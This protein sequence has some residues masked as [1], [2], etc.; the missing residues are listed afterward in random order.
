[1]KLLSGH[2]LLQLVFVVIVC[3]VAYSP[4]YCSYTCYE[5]DSTD[6]TAC[7]GR[8][9]CIAQDVCQCY[10]NN[11]GAKCEIEIGQF[12]V[13]SGGNYMSALYNTPY[14][15]SFIS[16]IECSL[17]FSD[18]NVTALAGSE[19]TVDY[20]Y[21]SRDTRLFVFF[22]GDSTVMHNN[23]V[24]LKPYI[25]YPDAV[26]PIVNWQS[27][28]VSRTVEKSPNPKHP[29]VQLDVI[30]NQFNCA[31]VVLDASN[32]R[33]FDNR[34]LKYSFI[35]DHPNINV[36]R[37]INN[38]LFSLGT[39]SPV[40]TIP[41]IY[42]PVMTPDRRSQYKFTLVVT[43]FFGYQSSVVTTVTYIS[44]PSPKLTS[45][46]T[47]IT[48]RNKDYYEIHT[49]TT[50]SSECGDFNVNYRWSQRRGPDIP[51]FNN[52]PWNN[53]DYFVINP[54]LFPVHGTS[55]QLQLRVQLE[56]VTTQL[57][58]DVFIVGEPLQLVIQGGSREHP[59][60]EDL[61]L[62]GKYYDP[63]GSAGNEYVEWTCTSNNMICPSG[64]NEDS[65]TIPSHSMLSGL[66]LFNF[67][68]YKNFRFISEQV[69]I[70]VIAPTARGPVV[71][72]ENIPY[73]HRHSVSL[74]LI[75]KAV[76][77]NVAYGELD[78]QW[79]LTS[80]T[81]NSVIDPSELTGSTLT[82]SPEEKQRYGI[83]VTA[84]FKSPGRGDLPVTAETYID[85]IGGPNLCN[86]KVTPAVGYA[87]STQ[88]ELA[89]DT[90][91]NSNEWIQYSFAVID[92]VGLTNVTRE[93]QV[94]PSFK[95]SM[96]TQLSQPL[97]R[98][99]NQLFLRV[100]LF[101]VYGG[102]RDQFTSVTVN[103]PITQGNIDTYHEFLYSKVEA[104]QSQSIDPQIVQSGI[105]DIA[106]SL[107]SPYLG[108]ASRDDL[109]PNNC[110]S[111][112]GNG[113]CGDLGCECTTGY[114]GMDCAIDAKRKLVRMALREQL[115]QIQSRF[116][117]YA[118]LPNQQQ[119]YLGNM[120]LVTINPEEVS[121]KNLDLTLNY[122]KIVVNATTAP[123]D[124]SRFQ[125]IV[126][127]LDNL[128]AV[129]GSQVRTTSLIQYS[130]FSA[131]VQHILHDALTSFS[132]NGRFPGETVD[133]FS[134]TQ[135]RMSVFSHY[136]Y[137]IDKASVTLESTWDETQR[138][139]TI[140]I[141]S[142]SE[143][144]IGDDVT[145]TN[146]PVIGFFVYSL[147]LNPYLNNPSSKNITS[148]VLEIGIN[149]N[150]V[151][152]SVSDLEEA[153]SILF[154]GLFVYDMETLDQKTVPV[155]KYWNS[156]SNTW[157]TEGVTT[158]D[159]SSTSVECLTNHL[160]QFAVFIEPYDGPSVTPKPSKHPPVKVPID[161]IWIWIVLGIFAGGILMVVVGVF[162]AW[163]VLMMCNER[164]RHQRVM[165][166][167]KA[168]GRLRSESRVPIF[169][170][171]SQITIIDERQSDVELQVTAK[172]D[173]DAN[174]MIPSVYAS[175]EVDGI[176]T[177]PEYVQTSE[178][179]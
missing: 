103:A 122:M 18:S 53:K 121:I 48:L 63:T 130:Q 20:D 178:T 35:V 110:Y 111:S 62:S 28:Y 45:N 77:D 7:F 12:V 85:V 26:Y 102:F 160:S 126:T 174:H 138:Y 179:L 24:I 58:F 54:N 49:E 83:Q 165:K 147:G 56:Y 21:T 97:A 157:S 80:G 172:Q 78:L 92:E 94:Y 79:K 155:C 143:Y 31:P 64:L 150:G 68:Y 164:A 116:T 95:T 125:I 105:A 109:C 107:N 6:S 129:I 59:I 36:Q 113:I 118:N 73:L 93:L 16:L 1:M 87:L 141:P 13:S 33:S 104:L 46:D 2:V 37:N 144:L 9:R 151:P 47:S 136:A 142:I 117:A 10:G 135:L 50:V 119:R 29:A 133:E 120:Q 127:I 177:S 74:P 52:F 98:F 173:S 4:V 57:L 66:H 159:Y 163:K 84:S 153:L 89:C 101:D 70:N 154:K 81:L 22:S 112:T 11:A 41:A 106:V 90:S 149:L 170:S 75:L 100:R 76:I 5:K 158:G 166:R 168:N 3:F 175:A 69:A 88:F 124:H 51:G 167:S 169:D 42:F 19:C 145:S 39:S 15:T 128:L 44:L 96:K 61:Y 86:F 91:V 131:Q 108:L 55:Y 132:F 161:R 40:V 139:K 67:T 17:V 71:R 148:E 146:L 123:L 34:P 156:K 60:Q 23:I 152:Q 115:M 114:T 32:S 171:V 72:I 25:N 137:S 8:G 65:T 162:I 176:M 38:F 27:Y 30:K 43:S 14:D 140:I 134:L 82:L 99:D